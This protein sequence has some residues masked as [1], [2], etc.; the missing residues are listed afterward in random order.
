MTHLKR[1]V[2]GI[3]E[4]VWCGVH[5]TGVG[6]M[7]VMGV[8]TVER[9]FA[10]VLGLQNPL[11]RLKPGEIIK[12]L[13]SSDVLPVVASVQSSGFDYRP[14]NLLL[15]IRSSINTFHHQARKVLFENDENLGTL[16]LPVRKRCS[17]DHGEGK[18]WP[19]GWNHLCFHRSASNCV[20]RPSIK[21]K[22][23]ELPPKGKFKTTRERMVELTL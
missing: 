4:S 23:C 10:G 7:L 1:S 5:G 12:L 15:E 8:H 17:C 14:A 20:C 2:V 3:E 19:G 11:R 21:T 22:K 13:L 9:W 6:T 18:F 16:D